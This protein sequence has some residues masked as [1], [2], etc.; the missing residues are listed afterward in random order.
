[1]NP[2]GDTSGHRIPEPISKMP[3]TPP[4][5]ADHDRQQT[6]S[7][8]AGLWAGLSRLFG[9]S[10]PAQAMPR[11]TGSGKAGIH[12][13]LAA[14]E[15]VNADVLIDGKVVAR[16]EHKA[17]SPGLKRLPAV[18]FDLP[19][20][21]KRVELRGSHIDAQGQATSFRKR[22]TV[23][24]MASVSHPLYD[25]SLPLLDRIRAF[26]KQSRLIDVGDPRLPD[27]I[28]AETALVESETRLNVR[29]P[30]PV[31]EV[32]CGAGIG[33]EN[34][35]FLPPHGLQTPVDLLSGLG[36]HTLSGGDHALDALLPP[37]VL[38]RYRRSVVVFVEIG[39]GLGALAWDPEG[40]VPQEPPNTAGDE[41]NPGARPATPNEGV[42]YWLH[43]GHIAEPALLLDD[44][45]KPR[46]AEAALTSIFKRLPL[47]AASP[48]SADHL[49]VDTAHPRN[50][51]QLHFDEPR[52][53][54][55]R[56]RSYDYHYSLY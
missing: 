32:L 26:G 37:S 42:W 40:V 4:S 1:M 51:L 48:G 7:P 45:Y 15:Q 49:L 29:L 30:A 28:G 56:L 55:L 47:S 27:G 24:D 46:D 14:G 36:G 41:G 9:R 10:A 21:L 50:L 6:P 16:L 20:G 38:A 19:I 33:I 11:G 43:Q 8:T 52:K 18:V 44:D 54:G 53:P 25:R 22:W 31:R 2:S 5:P 23:Y 13:W 35:Y 17:A 3:E 39:D 12:P 34:S